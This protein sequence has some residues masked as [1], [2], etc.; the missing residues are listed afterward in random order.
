MKLIALPGF[1][2]EAARYRP[3]STVMIGVSFVA[4]SRRAASVR[5]SRVKALLLEA[6]ALATTIS[7]V[8]SIMSRSRSK[9]AGAFWFAVE[10]KEI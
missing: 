7:S 6:L 10:T 8:C 4:T 3:K 1:D 9:K 5:P 2:E